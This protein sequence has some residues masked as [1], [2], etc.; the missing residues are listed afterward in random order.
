VRRDAIHW[1][2]GA[3]TIGNCTLRDVKYSHYRDREIQSEVRFGVI[4]PPGSGIEHPLYIAST[5]NFFQALIT[6][7]SSCADF[8]D[9]VDSCRI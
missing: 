2:N 7:R 6:I 9:V 5:K 3:K 1:E 4:D 8:F